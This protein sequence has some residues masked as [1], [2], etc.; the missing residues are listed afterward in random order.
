MSYSSNRGGGGLLYRSYLRPEARLIVGASH[1][2]PLSRSSSLLQ[3]LLLLRFRHP[4]L[5]AYDSYRLFLVIGRTS[6]NLGCS[7]CLQQIQVDLCLPRV[8]PLITSVCLSRTGLDQKLHILPPPPGFQDS[9]WPFG[10]RALPI[11]LRDPMVFHDDCKA[12]ISTL[13]AMCVLAYSQ[14]K[15][16][17]LRT[18]GVDIERDRISL[19]QATLNSGLIP[20]HDHP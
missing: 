1:W 8:L 14:N 19:L 9:Q 10:G 12:F 11:S 7:L 17:S 16:F 4:S 20:G 13:L 5:P 2:C 3:D 6:F 18:L 15:G